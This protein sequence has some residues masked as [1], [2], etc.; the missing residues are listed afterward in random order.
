MLLKTSVFSFT[1]I[2][3]KWHRVKTKNPNY[4]I[5]NAKNTSKAPYPAKSPRF[6]VTGSRLLLLI[7]AETLFPSNIKPKS[8][9]EKK[10]I[11]NQKVPK[12]KAIK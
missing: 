12:W 4:A 11:P 7:T 5:S 8:V 6:P 1:E 9:T 2:L 10:I 3:C